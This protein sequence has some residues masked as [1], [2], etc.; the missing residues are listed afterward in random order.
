MPT[1][2][3]HS[4][5]FLICLFLYIY[6]F[7]LNATPLTFRT[8]FGMLGVLLFIF[9]KQRL[10][11]SFW[12]IVIILIISIVWMVISQLYN[13]TDQYDHKLKL[14]LSFF[15]NFFGAYFLFEISKGLVYSISDLFK[16]IIYVALLQVGFIILFSISPVI[17][18]F[19][20]TIETYDENLLYHITYKRLIGIGNAK[21]FGILTSSAL[22]MSVSIYKAYLSQTA[23]EQIKYLI[24]FIIIS[25]ISF[26][27]ARTTLVIFLTAIIFIIVTAI[28]QRRVL[29]L[30][31][32]LLIGV[33]V[34]IIILSFLISNFMSRE[35]YDWAFELFLNYNDV[36]ESSSDTIDILQDWVKNIHF[37]LTTLIYGDG[38]YKG[39]ITTYYGGID[40]GY[41]REIYYWGIF[42]LFLTIYMYYRIIKNIYKAYIKVNGRDTNFKMLLLLLF[43]S[44]LIILFKGDASMLSEFLL[45]FIFLEYGKLPREKTNY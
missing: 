35:M 20:A 10:T 34:G 25:I 28:K 12:K 21:W 14:V 18:I 16:Y 9:N 5:F 27:V 33:I 40:I 1:K 29:L 7:N 6:A 8:V 17:Q 37:D 45:L 13:G 15:I 39:T 19:F 31:R 32:L 36:G 41:I 42:G 24:F 23:K 38:R 22:A 11:K 4:F 30:N 3:L 2:F 44:C 26:F 43:V